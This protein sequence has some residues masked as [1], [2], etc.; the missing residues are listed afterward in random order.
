MMCNFLS[1][2]LLTSSYS[3]ASSVVGELVP[4]LGRCSI[5]LHGDK[6]IDDDDKAAAGL[7]LPF[8]SIAF[9]SMAVVGDGNSVVVVVV[10]VVNGCG[11]DVGG[12]GDG[13]G[14]VG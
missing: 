9:T 13:V 1:K 2:N 10:V 14:A 12:G 11:N 4:L 3:S 5:S 7:C 6:V 8:V